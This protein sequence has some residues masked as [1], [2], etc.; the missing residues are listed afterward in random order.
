[1]SFLWCCNKRALQKREPTTTPTD[2]TQFWRSET[3]VSLTGSQSVHRPCPLG[4]RYNPSPRLSQL[5]EATCIPWLV[6]PSSKVSSISISDLTEPAVT[7][8]RSCLRLGGSLVIMLVPFWTIKD[9]SPSLK[10][11]ESSQAHTGNPSYSGGSWFKASP[12][13]IV[14]KTLP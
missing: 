2:C 9:T 12:E 14:H 1:M 13:Q 7:S 10:N 6:A 11:L 3:E 5:L 4:G 8:S